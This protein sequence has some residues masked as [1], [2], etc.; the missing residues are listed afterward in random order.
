MPDA[1]IEPLRALWKKVHR[2]IKQAARNGLAID[3]KMFFRQMPAARAHQ[4]R[5]DFL[6]E[7]V[8][9]AFGAVYS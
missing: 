4:Q 5:R 8:Y 6:V 9:L 3:Q 1:A 2:E 7:R